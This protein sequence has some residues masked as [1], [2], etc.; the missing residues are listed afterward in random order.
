MGRVPEVILPGNMTHKKSFVGFRLEAVLITWWLYITAY[1]YLLTA[2]P[3]SGMVLKST[4]FLGIYLALRLLFGIKRVP[5]D[6]L[7]T[8]IVLWAFVETG[9]GFHQLFTGR[10]LHYRYPMTGTF[11]NPGPFGT[12]LATGLVVAVALWRKYS[13]KVRHE[14]VRQYLV[15]AILLLPACVLMSTWS[16]AAIL[17]SAATLLYMYRSEVKPYRWWIVVGGS[18]TALV[19]YLF[20]QGSANGR[21]IIWWVSGHSILEHPWIG[22]GIGSFKH[23]YA[24]T[25]ARL[26]EGMPDGS[27]Q[28]ADVL[29]YSFNEWMHIGVE[30]GL[31]GLLFAGCTALLLLRYARNEG[32]TLKW[33]LPVLLITSLFS[34]T[35]ELLPFQIITVVVT[36]HL[37]SAQ[38]KPERRSVTTCIC[39][40]TLSIALCL[41]TVPQLRCRAKMN[42]EYERIAGYMDA[43]FIPDYY[44]MLPWMSDN[45]KFLF[46]FGKI[47]R[48]EKRWNDS[49]AMLRQG[50]LVSND[51]M[52]V[53]LQGNNYADMEE[54]EL[55]EA[56]YRRA[57]RMMPNRIYP[58][59]KL[60]LL[61]RETEEQEKCLA[62][63]ERVATFPVKVASPATRDMKKEAEEMIMTLTNHTFTR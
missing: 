1:A 46:N 57:Y 25:M 27:L 19:Y 2:Y 44:E 40:A 8:L 26:T 11:L 37:S 18:V 15:P 22:T 7:A 29:D 63:A 33:C 30:Q 52:F 36:A 23:R 3:V 13:G 55:A 48:E 34:Y 17:A 20:K 59:Y 12:M 43:H 56:C 60:M 16:R 31:V 45:P 54:P 61:Y 32:S 58:L 47:L 41:M 28:S 51:P 62:M 21:G 10:S 35:F 53:V 14:V 50:E 42:E 24:Q 38:V 39:Y 49:N 4:L 6:A 5:G 9:I